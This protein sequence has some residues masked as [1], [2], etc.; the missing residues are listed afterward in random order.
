MGAVQQQL[1]E[2]AIKAQIETE[3]FYRALR[4]VSWNC[5]E[6]QEYLDGERPLPW[7]FNFLPSFKAVDQIRWDEKHDW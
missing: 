2:A 4:E 3:Y 1:N 7:W 6:V 5:K